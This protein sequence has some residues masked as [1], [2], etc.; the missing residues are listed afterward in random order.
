MKVSS[1]VKIVLLVRALSSQAEVLPS[2]PGAIAPE[3]QA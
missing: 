3:Q 2:R 1:K